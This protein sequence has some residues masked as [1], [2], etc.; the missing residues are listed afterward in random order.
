MRCRSTS[1]ALLYGKGIEY[2]KVIIVATLSG[3][4]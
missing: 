1:G 3:F 4:L 2:Q